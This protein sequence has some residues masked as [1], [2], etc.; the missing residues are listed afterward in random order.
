MRRKPGHALTVSRQYT[1]YSLS[2]MQ[3]GAR[4]GRASLE[5]NDSETPTGNILPRKTEEL[6]I[7]GSSSVIMGK[8]N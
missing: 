4:I 2:V 6:S 5:N 7:C 8:K 3:L 1:E